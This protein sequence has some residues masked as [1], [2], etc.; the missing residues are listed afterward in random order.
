M[1]K[2]TFV[3]LTCEHGGNEVPSQYES[4]FESA[5]EALST[6]RG[7]DLGILPV[8]HRMAST[9]SAPIIFSTTTR[10]LVELNRTRSNPHL[11]SQY[12]RVLSDEDQ[13]R[14]IDA[15]HTPYFTRVQTMIDAL[16]G[17]SHC[18][19]HVGMHSFTDVLDEQ[20][21]AFDIAHL[22]DP[23][24][25][26][27][28]SFATQWQSAL[29]A[30]NPSLRYR[31]NEPYQGIDDGLTTSLRTRYDQSSYAGIEIEVR[32]GMLK[33][34]EEQRA[35]GELLSSTLRSLMSDVP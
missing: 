24:R 9:L 26:S 17:A 28:H 30:S 34:P 23:D 5:H 33:T 6:H 31:F 19:L 3:I 25:A 12:S 16:V 11:L 35:V 21:R 18:V 27:E 2:P 1:W 14:L 8:A 4:L 15:Y 32:Q 13:A 7:F 10:L 20:T 22:F 29:K